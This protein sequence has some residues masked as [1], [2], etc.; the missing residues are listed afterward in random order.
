VPEFK[1]ALDEELDKA[2]K[3]TLEYLINQDHPPTVSSYHRRQLKKAI[4][5]QRERFTIVDDEWFA[6]KPERREY[7]ASHEEGRFYRRVTDPYL[8]SVSRAVR[9]Q[10]ELERLDALFRGS[11]V[12]TFVAIA[13]HV[14]EPLRTAHAKVSAELAKLLQYPRVGQSKLFSSDF[15]DKV[16]PLK[17]PLENLLLSQQRLYDMAYGVRSESLCDR[18]E[19]SDATNVF[20]EAMFNVKQCI[21]KI[22]SLIQSSTHV[23]SG[24]LAKRGNAAEAQKIEALEA[25]GKKLGLLRLHWFH[26]VEAGVDC[27]QEGTWTSVV[28]SDKDA[29]LTCANEA[30]YHLYMKPGELV[31]FAGANRSQK[32]S[33]FMRALRLRTPLPGEPKSTGDDAKVPEATDEEPADDAKETET[34]VVPRKDFKT[35]VFA[36]GEAGTVVSQGQLAA[37]T[38]DTDTKVFS[39]FVGPCKKIDVR[40]CGP[41]PLEFLVDKL[42]NILPAP[43]PQPVA[44]EPSA[45]ALDALRRARSHPTQTEDDTA[46]GFLA[47]KVAEKWETGSSVQMIQV[48]LHNR[49]EERPPVVP[50]TE[51]LDHLCERVSLRVKRE[52]V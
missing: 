6:E 1:A 29:Y 31:T 46:S 18:P 24:E 52:D 45:T 14:S 42:G 12:E 26:A 30:L 2:A 8:D 37:W 23:P 3:V 44:Y 36:P 10:D 49:L 32:L 15:K 39:L 38:Y 51:Y 5:T 9:R 7:D 22:D 21:E 43:D 35:V 47:K 50:L 34:T 25:E 48:M 11:D 16:E 27:S 33:F 4:D 41:M 13:H 40:T 28:T 20:N 19:V 17:K